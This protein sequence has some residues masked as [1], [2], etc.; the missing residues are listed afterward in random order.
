V[1]VFAGV[2]A[3]MASVPAVAGAS[4]PGQNG[5]FVW[6][7]WDSATDEYSTCVSKPQPPL[8]ATQGIFVP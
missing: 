5:E 4:F 8:F 7:V 3:F 1:W 6:P 2:L